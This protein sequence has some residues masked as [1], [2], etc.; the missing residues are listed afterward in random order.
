MIS[1]TVEI[2][3]SARSEAALSMTKRRPSSATTGSPANPGVERLK[4]AP[5]PIRLPLGDG[6]IEHAADFEQVR[7]V[8]IRGSARSEAA[9]SMTKRRPS[10]ATTGS[11]AT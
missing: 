11:P 8:E 5:T 7:T 2:R 6:M 4:A 1:R 3:G 10:S 9:L